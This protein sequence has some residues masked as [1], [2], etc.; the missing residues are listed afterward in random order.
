MNSKTF[1]RGLAATL[2]FFALNGM[3]NTLPQA[4]MA[5]MMNLSAV[6]ADK[7][8]MVSRAEFLE[9]AGKMFDMAAK[10]M[11]LADQKMSAAQF[12]QF[13]HDIQH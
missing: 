12:K 10:K 13:R 3:A 1:G 11:K 2:A 4:R 6:D 7:D 5:E 9:A 8:G